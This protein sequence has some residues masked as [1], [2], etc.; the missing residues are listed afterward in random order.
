M[1]PLHFLLLTICVVL[2]LL[3]ACGQQ[4]TPFLGQGLPPEGGTTVYV[5]IAFDR[6]ID[7]DDESYR[8]EAIFMMLLTWS[9]PRAKTAMLDSTAKI[10]LGQGNASC[11][12]PCTSLFTYEPD[13]LCCDGMW[14]PHLE[15]LNVRGFS[16][17]RVVRYGIEFGP[18]NGSSS[19][20]YWAQCQGEYY[21]TARNPG[22]VRN[23]VP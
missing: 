15:F 22:C 9:D 19:V 12:Y 2:S 13:S 18:N 14:L 11:R 7:V 1:R 8:F 20:A 21:T 5:T 4:M 3:S 23:T 16:Q 10:A 6:L 17:D